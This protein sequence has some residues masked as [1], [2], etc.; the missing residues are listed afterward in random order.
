MR[1]VCSEAKATGPT[2]L[3]GQFV[4]PTIFTDVTNQMRIA[5]EE[6][7][8]PV[9]AIIGFEDEAEA[10]EIGNDVAFGLVAGVWTK[11]IGRAIRMANALKVGTVW[12]N[13]YRTYSYMMPFGGMKRSGIGRE[14][15]IEAVNEYLET[16]SVMLSIADK[17][18]AN[19]FVIG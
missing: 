17:A 3:G 10:I 14:H 7:F 1:V 9:L 18:P 5:Q 4:E 16:K 15:G 8:G 6:V 2:V 12:L 13:T 11:G 19:P